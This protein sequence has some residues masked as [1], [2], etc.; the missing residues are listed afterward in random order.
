MK[1]YISG[2]FTTNPAGEFHE[3]EELMKNNLESARKLGV[4]LAKMGYDPYVPHTHIGPCG[5]ELTYN[6]LMRINLSFLRHWADALFFLGP[7]RGANIE[8]EEAEMLGIP[9]FQSLSELRKFNPVQQQAPC[10]Q[11]K[12]QLPLPL[13]QLQSA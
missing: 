7:S 11:K 2:P 8:K 12:L 5:E 10:K 6:E 13:Q 3:N 1:I 4:E 9:V